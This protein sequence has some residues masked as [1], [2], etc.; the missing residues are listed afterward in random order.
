MKRKIKISRK[1]PQ[2]FPRNEMETKREKEKDSKISKGRRE[3]RE[4]GEAGGWKD[5][6]EGEDGRSNPR[7]SEQ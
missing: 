3:E 5:A 7:V 4:K 6:L 2:N 1:H